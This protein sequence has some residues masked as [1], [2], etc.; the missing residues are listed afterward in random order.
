MLTILTNT[1][2]IYFNYE[3]L[4]IR[5]TTYIAIL[6]KTLSIIS[7]LY[8]AFL[9]VGTEGA[10]KIYNISMYHIF[11]QALKGLVFCGIGLVLNKFKNALQKRI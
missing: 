11:N 1:K 8:G 3:L 2:T 4:K 10:S 5:I 7:F 6:F 9:V